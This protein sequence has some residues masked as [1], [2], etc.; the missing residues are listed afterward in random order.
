MPEIRH[1]GGANAVLQVDEDQVLAGLG[2][3]AD[4]VEVRNFLKL[5]LDAVGDLLHG[6][7]A[8]RTR[9]QR[10][11]HHRFNREGRIFLAAQLAIRVGT[12]ECQD[13]HQKHD[14]AL[15]A[16]RPLGPSLW[17]ARRSVMSSFHDLVGEPNLLPRTQPVDACRDDDLAFHQPTVEHDAVGLEPGD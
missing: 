11:H 6:F 3:A 8:R 15:V 13:Q 5:L 7:A 4:K 16:E 14:E 10:F 9:P 2:V 12:G 17:L 1:V